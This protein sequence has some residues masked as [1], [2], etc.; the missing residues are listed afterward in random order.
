MNQW[1]N[2]TAASEIFEPKMSKKRNCPKVAA[3]AFS[4]LGGM[5]PRT[6]ENPGATDHQTPAWQFHRCDEEHT[7]WGWSKLNAKE[8]LQIIQNLCSFE[9]MTWA[10]LKSQNG[11]K[12]Q[13]RG[14][15]HHLISV[16]GFTKKAKDR[17]RELRLDDIDELFSLRLGNRER[18]YAIKDGRV[19]R[20][21]WHD[22]HHGSGDEAYPT[23][24]R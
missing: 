20:F 5:Y 6:K 16:D 24:R 7:L 22:P 21:I 12:A 9:Q 15:N 1:L 4:K 2:I 3:D 10:A 19:L 14:T 13:G 18:L 8:R 11:G 23:S 17:L